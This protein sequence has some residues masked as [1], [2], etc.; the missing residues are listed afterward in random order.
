MNDAQLAVHYGLLR[1][2]PPDKPFPGRNGV[3]KPFVVDTRGAGV[4]LPLRTLVVERL[5]AQAMA[6]PAFDVVAGLAKSGT[7]W[8]AWLAWHMDKPFANVLLDGPRAS[9]LQRQVEGEVAGKRV[10]LIDNWV[11]SGTSIRQ[12]FDIIKMAGGHPVAALAIVR[13]ATLDL[14]LPFFAAWDLAELLEAASP[15]AT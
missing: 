6:S 3:A 14:G 11:R 8:A 13:R 7:V 12:A 15:H 10:L 2:A 5:N 9:G 4:H 1:F